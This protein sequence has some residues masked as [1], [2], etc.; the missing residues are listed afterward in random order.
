MHSKK[1]LAIVALLAF[2]VVAL[3]PVA[4]LVAEDEPELMP[5]MSLEDFNGGAIYNSGSGDAK[6]SNNFFYDC[7][8]VLIIGLV[9]AGALHVKAHKK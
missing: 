6:A 8:I 2:S 9:A 4:D 5:Q 3:A 1:V 7:I